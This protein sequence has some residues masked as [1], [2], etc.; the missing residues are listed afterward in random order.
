VGE[1]TFKQLGIDTHPE[2]RQQGPRGEA[3]VNRL[4]PDQDAR[5]CR[6]AARGPYWPQEGHATCGRCF[7]RQA[8]FTQV[9]AGTDAFHWERSGVAPRHSPLGTTQFTPFLGSAGE[10]VYPR[11]CPIIV[12]SFPA[13]RVCNFIQRASH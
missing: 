5:T 13:L 10:S 9:T 1:G 12:D 11:A 7:S 4:V 8:G 6:R 2:L 3:G